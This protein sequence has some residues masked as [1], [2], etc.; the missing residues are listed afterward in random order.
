MGRFVMADAEVAV[1]PDLARLGARVRSLREVAAL[2]QQ[3]VADAAGVTRVTV[4]RL[5]A[6]LVDVRSSS[7]LAIARALGV[8]PGQL[9]E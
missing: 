9:F 7:L 8:G 1:D 6:G 3:E 2:T 5:E 4:N